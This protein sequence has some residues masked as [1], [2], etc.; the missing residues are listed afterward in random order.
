MKLN[1]WYSLAVLCTFI[2][3]GFAASPVRIN[4]F[5]ANNATG[6]LDDFGEYSDWIELYNVSA[7]PVNLQNWSLTDDPENLGQWKFPNVTIPAGGYLVVIASG[8]NTN[9]P[10]RMH[11]SFSL[12]EGGEFLALIDNNGGVAS[13]FDPDY[14]PQ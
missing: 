8:R 5:M 12:S 10:T 6:L 13:V 11:T 14:P 7:Q 3:A 2:S 9:T 4:E 1:R